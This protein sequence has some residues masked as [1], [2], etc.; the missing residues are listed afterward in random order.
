M[1]RLSLFLA[2]LSSLVPSI[3]ASTQA[4][5]DTGLTAWG[6][7]AAAVNDSSVYPAF[8][9]AVNLGYGL[10]ENGYTLKFGL[11][12]EDALINY[13][14]AV[15]A[16]SKQA[17]EFITAGRGEPY[18]ELTTGGLSVHVGLPIYYFT[19]FSSPGTDQNGIKNALK[20]MYKGIGLQ[21][22]TTFAAGTTGAFNIADNGNANDNALFTNYDR[23][24]YKISVGDRFSIVPAVEADFIFAPAFAFADVKPVVTFNYGPVALDAKVSYYSI[25]EGQGIKP[26]GDSYYNTY[27]LTIDPKLT[28]GFDSLGVKGLKVFASS[29][30]PVKTEYYNNK[31]LNLIPGLGYR[32]GTLSLEAD[33]RINYLDYA[34]SDGANYKQTEYDPYAKAVY[35]FSL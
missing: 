31:G 8:I 20:W 14:G 35:T 25:A 12:A 2:V 15:P 30:I 26:T 11:A 6:V 4:T 23:I 22:Y 29:S 9:P 3:P 21:Y 16:T 24:A 7:D 10:K 17:A 1:K 33:L 13:S 28:V 32:L 19:P 5:L 27:V 18:A 34:G